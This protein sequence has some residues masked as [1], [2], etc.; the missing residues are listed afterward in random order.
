LRKID[1][2]NSTIVLESNPANPAEEMKDIPRDIDQDLSVPIPL[3]AKTHVIPKKD[4]KIGQY[5]QTTY[6]HLRKYKKY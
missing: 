3:R 1:K 6:K 4:L 2:S 5:L